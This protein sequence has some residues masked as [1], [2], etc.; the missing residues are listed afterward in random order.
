M[1]FFRQGVGGGRDRI[2]EKSVRGEEDH[3]PE[4]GGEGEVSEGGE[5]RD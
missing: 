2:Q 5:K 1:R 4:G 3:D